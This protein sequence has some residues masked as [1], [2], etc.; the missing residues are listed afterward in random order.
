MRYFT[1]FEDFPI[2]DEEDTYVARIPGEL[3]SV[4]D[5]FRAVAEILKFPE[6]F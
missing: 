3:M 5:F 1:F 6:Y 2:F 4:E